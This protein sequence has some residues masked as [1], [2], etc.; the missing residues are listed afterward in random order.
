MD[1]KFIHLAKINKLINTALHYG[2][3][4]RMTK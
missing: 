4:I 3:F 2:V 1:K